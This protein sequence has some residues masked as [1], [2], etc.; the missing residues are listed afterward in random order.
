MDQAEFFLILYMYIHAQCHPN[1]WCFFIII[2]ILIIITICVCSLSEL[3]A[4]LLND[5]IL[6][7][8][9][10]HDEKFYLCCHRCTAETVSGN[11]EE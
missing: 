7:L 6:V 9:E 5:I 10:K 1:V 4:L 2:I 3:H 11:K 8:L